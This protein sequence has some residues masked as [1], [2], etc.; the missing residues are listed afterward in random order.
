MVSVDTILIGTRLI[1]WT[2]KFMSS[3]Y[4]HISD[5]DYHCVH[6]LTNRS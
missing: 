2:V 6:P 5:T 3:F 1:Q 4:M